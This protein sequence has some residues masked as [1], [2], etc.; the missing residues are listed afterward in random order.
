[1]WVE[2]EPDVMAVHEAGFR[3]VVTLKD[4]SGDKLLAEDDP[5]R[6]DDK[7]FRALATHAELLDGIKRFYI[8]GDM[9]APGMVL[10]EELARRLGRHRCWLVTWRD[11]CKDAG[12]VLRKH[13]PDAIAH[14]IGAAEPYPI[15][16][17][18]T[19]KDDTLIKLHKAGAPATISTGTDNTDAVLRWPT[20]GRLIVITGTPNHGKTPWAR[21][22]M[23]HEQSLLAHARR[24]AGA[25]H[26]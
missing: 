16:G 5:K 2:G 22:V 1:V 21:F 12:D 14:D 23:V 9:D 13:G 3:Q 19:L 6:E 18:Q 8:A 15:E 26:G 10:R 11:G 7:R 17:L 20:E 24:P 25:R 4:G